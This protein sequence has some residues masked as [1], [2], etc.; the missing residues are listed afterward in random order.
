MLWLYLPVLSAGQITL[1][2]NGDTFGA[3]IFCL[4]QCRFWLLGLMSAGLV[5]TTGTDSS[6]QTVELGPSPRL[7]QPVPPLLSVGLHAMLSILQPI[8][9]MELTMAEY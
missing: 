2:D 1:T 3:Y 4:S 8:I 9:Q 5:V 6:F 7:S